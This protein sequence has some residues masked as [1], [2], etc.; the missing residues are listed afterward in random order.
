MHAR[1]RSSLAK[2]AVTE[3][4][5]ADYPALA[6]QW[7]VPL[8]QWVLLKWQ[9]QGRRRLLVGVNGAQGTGKTTLCAVLE[10]LLAELGA[11]TLTLSIDDFYLPKAHRQALAQQTH[12]LL[13]TRGVP[14]THDLPLLNHV[15]DELL[16]GRD[17]RAP[18]FDKSVDDRV[19]ADQWRQLSACDIVLFE[20]WCVGCPPQPAAALLKPE[21]ALELK[22]DRCGEWRRYVN[23]RLA[24]DYTA[25]FARLDYLVMLQAPSTAIVL[26][27]RS[28]QEQK[29]ARASPGKGVMDAAALR[30]FVQHYERLT[31]HCLEYLPGRADYLLRLDP[32]HNIDSVEAS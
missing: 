32:D 28:L 1:T 19:D 29:L 6:E 18:G 3:N 11:R 24:G 26:R 12:P 31:R 10:L 15:I 4:L 13:L 8:A 27:W 17:C 9:E 30:R 14:G 25:L 5:P 2:F 23:M 21:N 7:F 16:A 22:E 20:G